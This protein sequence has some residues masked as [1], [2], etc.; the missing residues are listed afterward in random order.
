M[1]HSR[2]TEFSRT[3][4]FLV[5]AAIVLV[6]YF[7][8]DLLIPFAFALTLAFLLAP[9][10]TRLE[11]RRVPRVVSVAIVGILVFTMLSAVGYVV[12]RQLLDVARNLP[13]YRLNIQKK[14]ASIHLPAEK[15]L[16]NAFTAVEDISGDLATTTDKVPTPEPTIAE[17]APVRII[18]PHRTQL[19]ATTELLMRFLRPIGICGVVIVF[20]IYLLM[21]RE[22]L[23][24]RILL[25]AG[26][27]RISLMT[28]AIQDAA[29]RIS[30]YLLFQ[31]AVNVAYG[32]FF[33]FGLFLIGVPNAT[34]WGV[35][36]AILRVIPYVGTAT[37][38]I[39]PLL[40]SVAISSTWWP[41]FLVVALF[42]TLELTAT[43]FVEPWLFSTRTGISSLALLA[44]AIFWALLWGW[45]GLILSTP[46][47]VCIVVMGRYVPQ[48]SFLHTLLGTDAEL[49]AEAHFYERL[50][51]MDQREA[52]T[53]ANRFLESN[54]LI[55]LYDSVFIPALAL[56]EQDRHQGLLDDAR[57]NFF[58]LSIGELVAELTDYREPAPSV[59]PELLFHP[60]PEKQSDFAVVCIA[61]SD[62]ADDLT[63]LMLGQLM[64]RAAHQTILLPAASVSN[65]ILETLGREPN[66]VVFISALPPFA[67]AQARAICQRV[68]HHL[69]HNRI[70]VGLW[71]PTEDPD[72]SIELTID[73]F[74]SGKPTLIVSSLS[75]A[76][77][78]A[79]Q[80]RE[81]P[82]RNPPVRV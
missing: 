46:L 43:N 56:V 24:H 59:I 39:V 8:R 4:P 7:A 44:M 60:A 3:G 21:K 76:L 11:S 18:D 9:A 33:G 13:Y 63:S 61:A 12:A 74:G 34:L 67:F 29:T 42:L 69:P 1:P 45:P 51:A 62:Q 54:S 27:G 58:F 28:Q 68:R 41:P 65:E 50:L 48:L 77:K 79:T 82:S 35:L 14:V 31:A 6:L 52:H 2:T 20:T 72:Q 32:S 70:V 55:Q 19:Q 66:T 5:L 36:A 73:R 25:L 40:V 15:S 47:T 17:A 30:Q 64:E 37:S 23:R 57:C 53:I 81:Q 16:E 75:Q 49:S 71:N 38:L 78:Q 26:M 22:E 80:W 10:V